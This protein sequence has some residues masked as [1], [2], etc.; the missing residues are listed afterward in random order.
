MAEK[1]ITVD[2]YFDYSCPWTYLS[3]KRLNQTVL[4]T[5]SLINW[6]PIEISLV[7][8]LIK[9]KQLEVSPAVSNYRI[10]D[11]QDWATYCSIKIKIQKDMSHA[12]AKK[13][14]QG[15]FFAIKKEKAYEY[16][17]LIFQSY[18]GE[19]L[20]ISNIEILL[21]IAEKSGL[22]KKEFLSIIETNHFDKEL[23][24]N[25]QEL[26]DKGGFGSP[27]MFVEDKIFF[28]NDRMNLVE[29]A[30]G[31]ASGKILVIPGQHNS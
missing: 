23:K 27:T 18:F 29:F 21:D 28:G 3:Y 14:L 24:S 13:A 11:L 25:A 10:K 9:N 4:R 19:C 6:K 16:S 8:S 30:I 7:R 2:Y 22:D 26:I 5:A 20:D 1:Q 17:G 15:A 12:I 31:Q